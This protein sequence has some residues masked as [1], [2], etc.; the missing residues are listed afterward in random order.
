MIFSE[1][2][3]NKR[4][5]KDFP[6]LKH[7][8]KKFVK[9][10]K[11][12]MMLSGGNDSA[13]AVSLLKELDLNVELCVHFYHDW[14]WKLHKE[15]ASKIAESLNIPLKFHYIGDEIKRRVINSKGKNVCRICK[16]I[17]KAECLKIAKENNIEV[18]A[19]GDTATER[20]SGP[21]M[22][23]LNKYGLSFDNMELA[24][25]PGRIAGEGVLFLRPLIRIRYEDVDKVSKYYDISMKRVGEANYKLREGCPVQYIN[26]DAIVT[27]KLL[28]DAYCVNKIATDIARSHGFKA[29]VFA[30]SLSIATI[31]QKEE[32][33]NLVKD[34]LGKNGYPIG[35]IAEFPYHT[36]TLKLVPNK[37]E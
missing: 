20:I 10:K 35:E 17:M 18:I 27:G 12:I 15:E 8:I 13:T 5:L 26:P 4:K 19:T 30:P 2:T 34:E 37:E 11:I 21:I 16:D 14:S 25:V 24:P 7:N 33:M 31:P 1:F 23:Y 3:Q 36:N 32:Y 22:E 29:S 28:N 6:E 9:D